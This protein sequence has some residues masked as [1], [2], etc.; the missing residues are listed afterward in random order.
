MTLFDGSTTAFPD[1]VVKVMAA[2][3]GQLWSPDVQIWRRRLKVTD[4]TQSIGI[5]PGTWEP[6]EQ[7]YEIGP[8]AP[9]P[10]VQTYRVMVQAFVKDSDEELG[11]SNHSVMNKAVRDTLYRDN[12]LR[13][14]LSALSITTG[15]IT[16]RIQRRG[17]T[18][19][20]Y[21]SNEISGVFFYLSTLEF[22]FE[23]ETK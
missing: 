17:I 22:W 7:S 23:T 5:Y 15:G 10:T 9:E 3:F 2:R 12:P 21:L 8:I 14:G 6:D 16:E 4:D 20:T 19:A 1:N 13:V 18:R 11:T